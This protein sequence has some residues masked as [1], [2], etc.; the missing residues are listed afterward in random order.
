MSATTHQMWREAVQRIKPPERTPL[1]RPGGPEDLADRLA[2]LSVLEPATDDTSRGALRFLHH[3]LASHVPY[4]EWP[5]L[6]ALHPRIKSWG[7]DPANITAALTKDINAGRAR[8]EMGLAELLADQCGADLGWTPE[9]GWLTWDGR[10]WRVGDDTLVQ[11]RAKQVARRLLARANMKGGDDEDE[12]KEK[13][14]AKARKFAL[15][16]Q[17]AGRLAAMANLARSE[18]GIPVDQSAWDADPALLTC[19]NGTIVLGRQGAELRE[20]RRADRLTRAAAG[21][22]EPTAKGESWRTFI[23]RALPDSD[24]RRFVQKLA[25][26]SMYGTNSERLLVILK[27]VTSTGKSTLLE[28]LAGVLG[29]YAEDF[30][31]S[32][33]RGKRDEG[34][35]PDLVDALPCRLIHTTEASDRWELH[36]DEVK[37]LT[38]NDTVRARTLHSKHFLKRRPAFVAWVGTN[39]APRIIGADTALWRRLVVVPFD[40][41]IARVAEDKDLAARL[42]REEGNAILTWL[43]EGWDLY[44][45]EGLDDMPAAVVQATVALREDLSPLD[46]WLADETEKDAEYCAP[47]GDLWSAYRE[48]CIDSGVTDKDRGNKIGLGQELTGR[49]FGTAFSGTREKRQRV[50]T[51]LRLRQGVDMSLT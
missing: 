18:P 6:L 25:G 19:Q 9:M 30:K 27:G 41:T 7:A 14:K 2:V 22:Y 51:G 48:W 23:E 8:T 24:V 26:Y 10:R 3:L 34:P 46:R 47:I 1:A 5:A 31:L 44:S 49:G 37:A 21:S 33:F 39:A 38:G 35:R 13:A 15:E 36:A 28:A 42:I 43:V 40:V 12:D 45:A 17:S 29:D 32:M 16:S 4:D 20:H 50:R 11:E